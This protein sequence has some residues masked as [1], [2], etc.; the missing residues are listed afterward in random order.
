MSE[1]GKDLLN[2]GKQYMSS[3]SKDLNFHKDDFD[4]KYDLVKPMKKRGYFDDDPRNFPSVKSSLSKIDNQL[5]IF[6]GKSDRV[7]IKIDK[8]KPEVVIA[9]ESINLKQESNTLCIDS[10]DGSLGIVLGSMNKESKIFLYDQN[11]TKRSLSQR[12][13]D[14][15]PGLTKNV[16]SIDEE[17]LD[18]F[19][20]NKSIDNVIFNISGYTALEYIKERLIFSK[21]ILKPDGKFY[22]VTYKKSGAP[23][24]EKIMG[25]IFGD[26]NVNVI[27]RGKGGYRVIEATNKL[28]IKEEVNNQLRKEISFSIFGKKFSVFTEAGL[29]SKDDLDVGTRTLLENTDLSSYRRLLDI[30]CGWGAVGL[31]ASS[32]NLNGEAVLTDVD[33]RAVRLA[34][35][36]AQHLGMGDRITALAVD[37]LKTAS[38]NFD[39][40]LSNPPFHADTKTLTD[41][42]KGARDKLE[43]GGKMFIV[44]EKSYLPKLENILDEA[45]G[46]HKIVNP[47]PINN[48]YILSTSK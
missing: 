4:S 12:N 20:S 16:K 5:T 13:I 41:I 28:N 31:I 36:N 18:N 19:S 7:I 3:G 24:H 45:F 34:N 32:I 47:E 38:G 26:E 39:L 15:N 14:A 33:T 27:A 10:G 11:V 6:T 43:S 2:K 48:F 9:A 23:T 22:C 44:V 1:W 17:E 8:E 35:L 46:R 37:D 29:F 21:K 40:I 42:F 25:N 30:G